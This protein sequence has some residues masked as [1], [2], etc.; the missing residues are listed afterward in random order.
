MKKRVII[1]LVIFLVILVSCDNENYHWNFEQSVTCVKEIKII[2]TN[3]CVMEP[4]DYTLIKELGIEEYEEI[5][6][7][8]KLLDMTRY[9]PNLATPWGI[10]VLIVFN[11]GEYD[12]IARKESCHYRYNEDG[13]ISAYNSWLECDDTQ[14]DALINKYWTAQ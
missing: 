12:V 8:I 6:E 11:N 13:I 2:D 4:A 3:D 7:D 1:L 14:Y 9:G 5:Y 10:C